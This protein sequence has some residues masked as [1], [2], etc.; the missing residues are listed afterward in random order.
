MLL[1]CEHLAGAGLEEHGVA[2]RL[3]GRLQ[4]RIKKL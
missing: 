4:G 3:L 2:R 1:V